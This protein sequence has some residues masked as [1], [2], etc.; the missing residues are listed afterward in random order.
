MWYPLELPFTARHRRA[1]RHAIRHI[2]IPGRKYSPEDVLAIAWRR[3]WLIVVPFLMVAVGSALVAYKLPSRWVSTAVI[4]IVPQR[5]PESYVRSTVTIG[6]QDRLESIRRGILSRPR[7]EQ[8]ILEFD[9]YPDQRKARVM[10][11]IVNRMRNQDVQMAAAKGDAFEVSFYAADPQLAQ[12]VAARLAGLFINENIKQRAEL[13]EGSSDFLKNQLQQVKSHLETTE[14]RLEAYRRKYAGQLPDQVQTNMQ[15]VANTQM[16]LQQ[17]RESI[18][19]DRDR[20]LMVERQMADVTDLQAANLARADQPGAA[21]Q[22]A[23]GL[24]AA[25]RLLQASAELASLERQLKRE[26]PD[27]I[28]A[29]RAVSEL[30]EEA[31]SEMRRPVT[32]SVEQLPRTPAELG[33]LNRLR[34][35]EAELATI[36]RNISSKQEE[37]RRLHGVAAEY[38][39]RLDAAPARESELTALMRDYDTVSEQYKELLA[40]SKAAEMSEDLE[41]RRGGEQFRL[42]EQARVP[43]RPVSPQRSIIVLLGAVGGLGLGVGM[44]VLLELHDR[45]LRTKDDVLAALALPVLAVVP[46][47]TTARE[48]RARRTRALAASAATALLFVATAV[49]VWSALTR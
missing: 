25:E 35:L 30:E 31:R 16:Q 1:H 46:V 41:R 26:H 33:R 48:R 14:R 34:E 22:P 24:P 9:L 39:S 42:V 43:Q 44:V 47:M 8:I 36:D 13:A 12:R 28:R 18:N 5:V 21:D 4:S 37:E 10:D 7:L 11:D 17:V 20:R 29:R 3:R 19:R 2:M 38:Q 6:P 49:A 45:S 23:A 15:A 27:V 32:A 40:N